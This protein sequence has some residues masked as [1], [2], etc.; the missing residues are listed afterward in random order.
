MALYGLSESLYRSIETYIKFPIR[1]IVTV[2]TVAQ[3]S[4]GIFDVNVGQNG[5]RMREISKLP[6]VAT[7]TI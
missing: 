2:C 1:H 6:S 7:V 3:L 4:V 5:V